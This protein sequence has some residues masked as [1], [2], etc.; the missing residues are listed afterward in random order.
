MKKLGL[1]VGASFLIIVILLVGTSFWLK[2]QSDV[3]AS[4]LTGMDIQFA[5]FDVRYFPL[6]AIVLTDLQVKRGPHLLNVP[7][8]ELFPD[9]R[10]ILR[11]E[12]NVKKTILDDP[13]VHAR[14]FGK[15][16][17]DEKQTIS[18]D[19]I[20]QTKVVVNRGQFVLEGEQ[21]TRLPVTLTAQAEKTEKRILVQLTQANIEEIGLQ[22]VGTI[23]ILALD[24]LRFSVDAAK[25]TFKPAA[26]K[27]FLLDFQY[28]TEDAAARLPDIQ[29]M[30]AETFQITIDK[31]AK[32]IG[33]S[34]ETLNLDQVRLRGLDAKLF[35]GRLVDAH[36]TEGVVDVKSAL[37]WIA[38]NVDAKRAMDDLLARGKF[39]RVVPSGTIRI[40]SLSLKGE[41]PLSESG[42]MGGIADGKMQIS[43]EDLVLDLVSQT[44]QEQRL[45]ITRLESTV[46]IVNGVPSI[47]VQQ[48]SFDSSKGGAGEISGAFQLPLEMKD[49]IV[50]CAID[51]LRIFDSTLD[52]HMEKNG[53]SKV[54]VDLTYRSPSLDIS[55]DGLVVVPG[56]EKTDVEVWLSHL[57][58]LRMVSKAPE[59]LN[60][61]QNFFDRPFDADL[62]PG[63]DFS[64]K[65]RVKTFQLDGLTRF[66]DVNLLL[67]VKEKQ[68]LLNS[69]VRMCGMNLKLDAYLMPPGR[70]IAGVETHGTDVDLNS[71]VACFSKTLPVYLAGRLFVSGSFSAQGDTPKE[72]IDG[73]EG[74]L[75]LTVTR[76]KVSRVSGLDPRLGFILDILEAGGITSESDDSLTLRRGVVDSRFQAGRLEVDRFTLVG[77]LF[78]A[79]G[80]GRF[81]LADKHLTLS[82]EVK[83]V[84]GT[85]SR[86]DVNRILRKGGET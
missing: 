75:M 85:T 27:Q 36:C 80:S 18:F 44:D 25:G 40:S 71:L 53:T 58:V 26:V 17:N 7:K 48:L 8:I 83:T 12:I 6:P 13:V 74:E 62:I 76:A 86:L 69:S 47:Q 37:D 28:L 42:G 11:G 52:L 49:A 50:R 84:M 19:T 33:F 9:F 16:G 57:K 29:V 31:Q 70:L 64:A 30:D 65:A 22:F 43:A 1:I 78:T 41:D 20:P 73:A 79:R 35:Q 46:T 38:Q 39:K 82:G 2:S 4:R 60:N 54:P 14:G 61:N 72:V 45:T 34:A 5:G 77:P 56:S 63:K 3:I 23:D 59:H 67:V 15:E 24:P 51:E 66:N 21:G 32:E 81:I 10:H 55:A 68:A